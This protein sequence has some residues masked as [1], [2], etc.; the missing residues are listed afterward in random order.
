SPAPG[1]YDLRSVLGAVARAADWRHQGGDTAERVAAHIRADAG[2]PGQRALRL[3]LDLNGQH[4]GTAAN[5]MFLAARVARESG[6]PVELVLRDGT[7]V[8][9]LAFGRDGRPEPAR[10]AGSAAGDD[11][12]AAWDRLHT[13]LAERAAA[14]AAIPGLEERLDRLRAAESALQE[15][16]GPERRRLADHQVRNA[17]IRQRVARLRAEAARGAERGPNDDTAQIFRL[18][19]EI[20]T[21]LSGAEQAAAADDAAL[22][23]RAELFRTLEGLVATASDFRASAESGLESAHQRVAAV[24][25]E[26][27][28]RL[29]SAVL[30]A[31]RVTTYPPAAWQAP[32][33]PA[34]GPRRLPIEPVLFDHVFEMNRL[35]EDGHLT[36]QARQAASGMPDIA[37]ARQSIMQMGTKLAEHVRRLVTAERPLVRAQLVIRGSADPSVR[38]IDDSLVQVIA[39]TLSK[40]VVLYKQ[41]LNMPTAI[42]PQGS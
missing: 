14:Q 32:G 12:A 5:A 18:P 25:P 19:D 38:N 39:D 21:E 11:L 26:V 7:D 15:R 3:W 27:A 28:G 23:E 10:D 30:T 42:C 9:R 41:P 29:E 1:N 17:E 31:R 33:R 2:E 37:A 34:A 4:D 24:T 40:R 13:P 35:L 6:R 36:E 8:T 16:V 20:R 22:R